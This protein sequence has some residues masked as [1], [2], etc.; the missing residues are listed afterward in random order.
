MIAHKIIDAINGDKKFLIIN[1][2]TYPSLGLEKHLSW[3]SNFIAQPET[4]YFEFPVITHD[5][6]FVQPV[7]EAYVEKLIGFP[8]DEFVFEFPYF[9]KNGALERCLI[10]VSNKQVTTITLHDRSKIQAIPLRISL[11]ASD[12]VDGFNIEGTTF[13]MAIERTFPSHY[14]DKIYIARTIADYFFTC[15][16]ILNSLGI[17]CRHVNAPKALNKRRIRKGKAPKQAHTVVHVSHEIVER[18]NTKGEGHN[19]P[20]FHMRR[21]HIRRLPERTTWVRPCVVGCIANGVIHH[22]YSVSN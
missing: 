21:G 5:S 15:L 8:F 9:E 6:D 13:N 19:S 22:T 10:L 3:A 17:E 11:D 1:R 7:A 20:R 14:F 18:A 2:Q 16:G 12:P 4:Q